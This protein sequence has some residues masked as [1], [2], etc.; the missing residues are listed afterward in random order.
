MN[1]KKN[2][3]D[4]TFLILVLSL[5]F[6]ALTTLS[7]KAQD[8]NPQ[9]RSIT[10]D[11]FASQRPAAALGQRRPGAIKPSP[12]KIRRA[13][14][15]QVQQ[16][17]MIPRRKTSGNQPRRPQG[18]SAAQRLPAKVSEIGVTIWRLRPPRA[19]D[20]GPKFP[21][22]LPDGTRPLWTPERV[23][24]NTVFN[25][26]DKVRIAVESAAA[27]YL[28]IVNSEVYTNG[29]IGHPFL[30][31]PSAANEDNS[32]RP[33]LLVEIPDQSEEL[34]YFNL[35]AKR[36]NYAGELLTVIVSPRPLTNLKVEADGRIKSAEIVA[37]LEE[38]TSVELYARIDGA[39][40]TYSLAESQST[41]GQKTRQLKREQAQPSSCAKSRQLTRDEPLPQNIYRVKTST[42]RP[43]VLLVL[44]QTKNV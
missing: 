40:E 13:Q 7:I 5:T 21:V 9:S 16:A 18:N 37:D 34:P 28:Y 23:T 32:V 31:F 6:F 11:D 26:D 1:N 15:K 25:A 8:N 22:Q 3:F 36:D 24:A 17:Q 12:S 41:C 35:T 27:G 30:I 4:F 43:A 19:T 44:L 20:V 10:S 33:G 2:Y 38:N 39:G 14:Y 42:G 29:S